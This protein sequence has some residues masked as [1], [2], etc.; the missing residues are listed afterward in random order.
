MNGIYIYYNKIEK[1]ELSG[2]DK[3]VLWQIS[4][5]NENDLDCGLFIV[6]NS[7]KGFIS[8]VLLR[9]PFTNISPK[10]ELKRKMYEVD[11]IYFRRPP[12]ITR[13]MIKVFKQI[14]S[15]N[16]KIKI[17]QEIPTYPYDKELIIKWYNFPIYIKDKLNRRKLHLVI[18]KIA[19]QGNIKNI[20]GIP[21]LNFRN[22]INFNEIDLRKPVESENN[23]INI[24]AVANMVSWQG[25]E[26]VI[27]GLK[28][29]YDNLTINNKIILH[30]VG[31]GPELKKYINL[32]QKHKLDN[33]IQFHG[34]LANIPLSKIYDLCD[35][36]LDAFGRYKTGNDITT[37]LKSR[38]YLA[39]GLPIIAGSQID[40]ITDDFPYSL[41][42]PSDSSS[43]DF[44]EIV[45]FYSKMYDG[46][47]K[48]EVSQNIREYALNKFSNDKF[49]LSIIN[50]IK[51]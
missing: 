41:V 3:K 7:V 17:I 27:L 14:K 44:Y 39:K 6:G 23:V 46:R 16:P 43:V 8:K 42:F 25:Y 51:Q 49:M 40:I 35:L 1:S 32:T 2:I 5:F 21:T 24:C 9:L 4:K 20:F 47:S 33:Y 19:V 28:K 36:A 13:K 11:Y 12:A 50:Y 30:F 22:E 38:E 10:W 18:D 31:E 45:K 29:Y 34:Y 48:N 26:R 15:L 37:S